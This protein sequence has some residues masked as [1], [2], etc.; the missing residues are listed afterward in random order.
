MRSIITP[1]AVAAALVASSGT[2]VA[3]PAEEPPQ[4]QH[5]QPAAVH[6]SAPSQG[7][8]DGTGA[9]TVVLLGTGVAVSL[10]GAASLG[11]YSTRR[12]LSAPRI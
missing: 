9:L 4:S 2:A 7:S 5:S 3:K 11:A 12:R 1:I 10:A 8:H 6:A